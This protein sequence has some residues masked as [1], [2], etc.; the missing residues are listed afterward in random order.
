MRLWQVTHGLQR[1][2]TNTWNHSKHR[3]DCCDGCS[4]S[5]RK[6]ISWQIFR[7]ELLSL[8]RHY[9]LSV[10]CS[11][12][13]DHSYLLISKLIRLLSFWFELH[14]CSQRMNKFNFDLHELNV[15]FEFWQLKRCLLLNVTNTAGRS[16]LQIRMRSIRNK[17]FPRHF[18]WAHNSPQPYRPLLVYGSVCA[19][20]MM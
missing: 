15:T 18:L 3:R 20:T 14:E 13:T 7:A 2:K 16:R 5:R 11:M 1:A 17:V 19:S 4:L 8:N 10:R 6:L 9:Y 12:C